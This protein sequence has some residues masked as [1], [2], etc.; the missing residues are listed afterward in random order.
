MAETAQAAATFWKAWAFA[1]VLATV[2]S[3]G[4]LAF[5]G[6]ATPPVAG[7]ATQS[8]RQEPDMQ[9]TAQT[10]AVSSPPADRL[11]ERLAVAE[12]G[13]ER[14]ELLERL[15][16]SEEPRFTYAI[17]SVLE[18][19]QL[20][21]VR[22]CA[23][24]ALVRQTTSAAQ[25]WLCDLAEDPDPGVHSSALEALAL[26]ADTS[27]LAVVIEATHSDDIE[28]RT[29]AVM[30][31]LKAKREQA[32]PAFVA[33]LPS[34]EA[35]E[36]LSS[37][38]DALGESHDPQ[39]LPALETLVE[40]S[41]RE[42][43]IH[44]IGAI[45][46]LGVSAA[47]ARLEA[48]LDVGSDDEFSAA[49]GALAK[50]APDTVL[51]KLRQRLASGNP[52]RQ[53]MALS[54]ILSLDDPA[55]VP[56][57]SEQLRAGDRILGRLVLQKLMKHPEPALESEISALATGSNDAL[58]GPAIRALSRLSTPSARSVLQRLAGEPGGFGLGLLD[59]SKGSDEELRARRIAA[60]TREDGAARKS[61]VSLARDPTDAAQSAVLRYLEQPGHGPGPLNAVIA[62]AP[63]STVQRLVARADSLNLEDRQILIEG[64][65]RRGEA[66]FIEPLR[67]A[68]HDED[69]AVRVS[70]LRGLVEQGD[71]SSTQDVQR[72]ATSADASE[73]VVAVELLGAQH[74]DASARTIEALAS[75]SDTEVAS[76]ALHAVQSKS[77]QLAS[78]LA[79]A[80]FRRASRDARL[81]LLA[82]LTDLKGSVLEPL[83][84]LAL[85]DND[86]G[87]A[88]EAVH[89][90]T[91][92]EG[93]QNAQ[94]LLA[95][96]ND[97][98]RSAEVRGEAAAGLRQ[99][100]GPLARA[101]QALLDTLSEPEDPGAYTCNQTW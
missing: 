26:S 37:L 90:F 11:L 20:S 52:D 57:L 101:N 48:L 14:C 78:Q 36:T 74:D 46:E 53:R 45:G 91:A 2:L 73:R 97:A 44:A 62:L 77:P 81:N 40:S 54:A 89:A 56:L 7:Q 76:S 35:R 50:L 93:P 61:V 18:R 69:R 38:I 6:G 43:H 15:Q 68:L 70:A 83:Y 29:S 30:A 71:A 1:G 47:A 17:T 100:G 9:Q 95:V 28:I 60:L 65:A 87:V 49:S 88:I 98:R 34:V 96:V 12:T 42:S 66:Q 10:A 51:V 59:E 31:L 84:E 80:A 4:R 19:A 16:P 58:K 24:Q 23:T 86:D 39:A 25:S 94:R 75:D 13:P 55:V 72:L 79:L 32:F 63:A 8:T 5:P 27:A 67:H 22:V 33:L 92:G 85:S 82:S 21:S 64:L 41:E 99:L 3:G